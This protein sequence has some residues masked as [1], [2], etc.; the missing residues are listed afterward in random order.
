MLAAGFLVIGADGEQWLQARTMT[1]TVL[2][3]EPENFMAWAINSVSH[4]YEPLNGYRG[5]SS[6]QM[7][8]G[9][10]AGA[11]RE[12]ERG[13]ELNP[14]SPMAGFLLG[15]ILIYAGETEAGIAR[16]K[17]AAEISKRMP[18]YHAAL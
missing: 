16:A 2:D 18:I 12:A 11:R 5:V 9:D 17:A 4:L 14:H 7:L 3:R 13:L 6:V 1:E 10:L 8:E 15:Q